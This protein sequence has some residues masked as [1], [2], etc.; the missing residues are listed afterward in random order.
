L[1]NAEAI[2][3]G[4]HMEGNRYRYFGTMYAEYSVLPS[5]AVKVNIGGDMNNE[6]R[7]IYKD[8][9]TLLGRDLDGIG[10]AYEGVQTNYLV[11]GTVSYNESFDEHR[12]NAV[13]GATF[14]RFLRRTSSIEGS[15]FITDATGAF[16]FSLADPATITASSAKRVNQLLSYLGRINYAY[17]DRYM[18]T[19]SY[20]IDGS[21]R[22]GEANRFGYFPSFSVGG[23]IYQDTFFEPLCNNATTFRRRPRW[24]KTGKQ[25]IRNYE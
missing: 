12:F 5:L 16:N 17:R 9:S 8:R 18:L 1:D 7:T 4:T 13:G 20:R 21:S 2:I 15:N 19:A 24:G 10:T 6:D 11:E 23:A 14:Q 3:T 25:N 22:F